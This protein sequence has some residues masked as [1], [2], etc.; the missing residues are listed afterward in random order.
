MLHQVLR[1]SKG[2]DYQEAEAYRAVLVFA[3]QYY[4]HSRYFDRDVWTLLWC[5]K[6]PECNSTEYMPLYK[7]H[8]REHEIESLFERKNQILQAIDNEDWYDLAFDQ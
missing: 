8:Y 6:S 2:D 7:Q 4:D 3:G 5:E 1:D